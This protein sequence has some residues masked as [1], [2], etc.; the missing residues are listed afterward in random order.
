MQY[1]K[2]D[3]TYYVRIDRGE[4]VMECLGAFAKKEGIRLA[5]VSGLGAAG[6]VESGVYEVET[7]T[8]HSQTYEGEYEILSLIGTV[9]SKDGEPYLHLHISIGD[10]SGRAYGGHLNRAVISGTCELTIQEAEGKI[11]RTYDEETGLNIF[12]IG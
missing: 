5:S 9:T 2:F 6:F 7:K 11:D 3:H 1:Q 4:E 10:G 12:A 8:Y